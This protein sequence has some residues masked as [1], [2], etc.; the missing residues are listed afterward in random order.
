METKKYDK[1]GRIVCEKCGANELRNYSHPD[2]N[3]RAC[4]DCLFVLVFVFI[5]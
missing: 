5:F 3:I 2:N 4:K 1:S